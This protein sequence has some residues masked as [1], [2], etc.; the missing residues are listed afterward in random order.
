ML[1]LSRKSGEKIVFPGREIEI[2]VLSVKGDRVRI[3]IAAPPQVAVHREEVWEALRAQDLDGRR[4][5]QLA[6]AG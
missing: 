6:G 3:G 4:P 1:V 2:V 5:D